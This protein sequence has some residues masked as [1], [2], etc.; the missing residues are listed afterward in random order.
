MQSRGKVCPLNTSSTCRIVRSPASSF[1]FSRVPAS[2]F[3]LHFLYFDRLSVVEAEEMYSSGM[4]PVW[5]LKRRVIARR[6]DGLDDSAG[7]SSNRL[8][9]FIKTTMTMTTKRKRTIRPKSSRPS[10]KWMPYRRPP[11]G[12]SIATSPSPVNLPPRTYPAPYLLSVKA[13]PAMALEK[14]TMLNKPSQ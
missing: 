1:P 6:R 3:H 8:R 5:D 10:W 7:S 12:V 4:I 11:V 9:R 14:L 2:L 13:L